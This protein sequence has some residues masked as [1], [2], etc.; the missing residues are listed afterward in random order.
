M[1]AVSLGCS[2]QIGRSIAGHLVPGP[3]DMAEALGSDPLVLWEYS[4]ARRI[5][6]G[7]PGDPR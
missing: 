1:M 5:L 3:R 2:D 7:R 6:L 4:Q